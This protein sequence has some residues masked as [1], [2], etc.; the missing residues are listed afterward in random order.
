MCWAQC[1]KLAGRKE[2][3]W[4]FSGVGSAG[5]CGVSKGRREA[6]GDGHPSAWISLP[7]PADNSHIPYS[8]LIVH[9]NHSPAEV[10][11]PCLQFGKGNYAH[12]TDEVAEA[13]CSVTTLEDLVS[14][15]AWGPGIL[16]LPA[17]PLGSHSSWPPALGPAKASLLWTQG[18]PQGSFKG[19]SLTSTCPLL[20]L[21]E[22]E[23]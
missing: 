1:T 22:S 9:L 12:F 18:W 16:V 10:M 17:S 21:G 4:P 11:L 19:F 13:R 6:P 15:S 5:V 7:S 8:A 3:I 2:W 14:V 23:T 20:G